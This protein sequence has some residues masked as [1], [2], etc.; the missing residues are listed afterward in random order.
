MN[1]R[2]LVRQALAKFNESQQRT[3]RDTLTYTEQ[4]LLSIL[5]RD[6]VRDYIAEAVE[7]ESLAV[8][9]TLVDEEMEVITHALSELIESES[10]GV[11]V[12]NDKLPTKDLLLDRD[13]H[14]NFVIKT[15]DDDGEAT[16]D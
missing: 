13:E 3:G 9:Q 1:L 14:G 11:Y 2:N 12:F 6:E 4:N 16:G 8:A 15:I 7:R 10:Q 5:V